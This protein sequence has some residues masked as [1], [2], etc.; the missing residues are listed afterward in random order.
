M[1]RE[2]AKFIWNLYRIDQLKSDMALSSQYYSHSLIL[3]KYAAEI[4]FLIW[5]FSSL[6]A[7]LSYGEWLLNCILDTHHFRCLL[8][9]ILAWTLF[10]SFLFR[11][12]MDNCLICYEN[13][14]IFN[15]LLNIFYNIYNY[16]AN[17]FS[18]IRFLDFQ[19]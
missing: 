4:E 16:L 3:Y 19:H 13:F 1:I 12:L 15:S 6:H 10:F 9:R 5:F 7:F 11:M 18:F 14:H 17:D 2:I 8:K